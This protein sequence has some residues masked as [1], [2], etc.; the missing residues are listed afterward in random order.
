MT[1]TDIIAIKKQKKAERNKRYY[2]KRKMETTTTSFNIFRYRTT[3][4]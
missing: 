4:K 3:Q 2:L 1:D